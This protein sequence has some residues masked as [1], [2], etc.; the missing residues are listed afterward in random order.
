M[1]EKI[2]TLEEVQ[3]KWSM[4]DLF[5]AHEALRE[6]DRIQAEMLKT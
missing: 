2:A 1:I 4:Q 3:T 5:D 6:R